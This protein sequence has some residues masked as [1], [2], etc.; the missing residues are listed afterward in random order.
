MT[1]SVQG[2]FSPVA[3]AVV[4]RECGPRAKSDGFQEFFTVMTVDGTGG[5]IRSSEIDYEVAGD[6]ETLTIHWEMSAC[7]TE[8]DP[9]WCPQ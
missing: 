5:H 7:G 6:T 9:D 4:D 1:Q 8:I 2:S 3:G